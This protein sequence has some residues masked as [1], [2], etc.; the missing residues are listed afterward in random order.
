MKKET[1][2]Q[3]VT[4]LEETFNKTLNRAIAW[5]I[6]NDIKDDDF[7]KI[8]RTMVRDLRTLFPND[9]LVAI[10]REYQTQLIMKKLREPASEPKRLD[11]EP[12]PPPKEWEDLKI[13]LAHQ[14]IP[15]RKDID[16]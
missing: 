16:G 3:G 14:E 11:W 8:V 13:K 6:L 10:V 9:N 12:C 1:F 15:L 7:M 5:E 2:V 4:I